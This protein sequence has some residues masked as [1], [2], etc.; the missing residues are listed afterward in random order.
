MNTNVTD[1]RDRYGY[2]GGNFCSDHCHGSLIV[3]AHGIHK[4]G[5]HENWTYCMAGTGI[6]RMSQGVSAFLCFLASMELGMEGRRARTWFMVYLLH[7][8][9][10]HRG[11]HS[12][13]ITHTSIH[14]TPGWKKR[15]DKIVMAAKRAVSQSVSHS[16]SCS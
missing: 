1:G 4:K 6:V 8:S 11:H 7:H 5:G 14:G 13:I 9:C 15:R 16:C 10:K 3:T 12:K 2:R